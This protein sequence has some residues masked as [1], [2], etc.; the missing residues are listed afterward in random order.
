M[1]GCQLDCL[2]V[3]SLQA[4]LAFGYVELHLLPLP[5]HLRVPIS[6]KPTVF[7]RLLLFIATALIYR[8]ESAC[9]SRR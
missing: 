8:S 3:L 6:W 4:L 7:S 9:C 2:N 1:L 5:S